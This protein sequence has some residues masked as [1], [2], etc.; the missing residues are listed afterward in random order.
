VALHDAVFWN[1]K[2]PGSIEYT[3]FYKNPMFKIT[4]VHYTHNVFTPYV[5]AQQQELWKPSAAGDQALDGN[6]NFFP[7]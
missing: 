2:I 5:E 4:F 3:L 7:H 6:E 1:R